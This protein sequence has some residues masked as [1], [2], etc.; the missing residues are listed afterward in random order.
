MS[1]GFTVL[2]DAPTAIAAP[3]GT[4][5]VVVTVPGPATVVAT[6]VTGPRGPEGGSGPIG[7][8]GPQGPSAADANY[9]HDQAGANEVWHIAHG[10]GAYPNATVIDSLGH[11]CLGHL[12]YIDDQS[13]D[14]TFTS[15]ISGVAYLS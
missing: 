10:L 5:S 12:E 8:A 15:A 1:T 3:A 2:R 14:I 9:V 11:L 13:M 6:G 4:G 7:P